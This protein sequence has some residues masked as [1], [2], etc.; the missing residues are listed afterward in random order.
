[1]TFFPYS[2]PTAATAGAEPPSFTAL[3]YLLPGAGSEDQDEARWQWRPP[4]ALP[5]KPKGMHRRTFQRLRVRAEAAMY[6]SNRAL[7]PMAE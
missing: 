3:D 7:H 4:G 5:A 2:K 6:C 1:M